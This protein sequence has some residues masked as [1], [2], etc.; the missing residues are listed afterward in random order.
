MKDLLGILLLGLVLTG[1]ALLAGYSAWIHMR[2]DARAE[3]IFDTA[4]E[5]P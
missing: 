5:T 3:W 4:N 1:A 2:V